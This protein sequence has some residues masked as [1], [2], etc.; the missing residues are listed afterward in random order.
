MK[1][2]L[3]LVVLSLPTPVPEEHT[4]P[5]C[6]L[7]APAPSVHPNVPTDAPSHRLRVR[8]ELGADAHAKGAEDPLL[9]VFLRDVEEDTGVAGIGR[10]DLEEDHQVAAARRPQPD[11]DARD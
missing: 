3:A 11:V 4:W 5:E 2:R 1:R 7:T 6:R 8:D 10:E 9:A